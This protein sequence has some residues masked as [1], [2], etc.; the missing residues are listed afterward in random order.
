MK[1]VRL[2]VLVPVPGCREVQSKGWEAVLAHGSCLGCL[3]Y[4]NTSKDG[5]ELCHIKHLNK[6]LMWREDGMLG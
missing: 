6:V 5:K 3:L 1:T 2:Q 4:S